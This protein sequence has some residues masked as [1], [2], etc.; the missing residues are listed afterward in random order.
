MVKRK[1]GRELWREVYE[2][3]AGTSCAMQKRKS[4]MLIIVHRRNWNIYLKSSWRS[5][6]TVNPIDLQTF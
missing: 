4:K 5:Q 6:N 1:G 3:V 2:R